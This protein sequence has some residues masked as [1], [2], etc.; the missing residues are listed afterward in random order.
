MSM[1]LPV[2]LAIALALQLSLQTAP[3][4]DKVT[5]SEPSSLA[6]EMESRLRLAHQLGRETNDRKL[7]ARIEAAAKKVKEKLA[8]NDNAGAEKLVREIEVAVGIDPGGWAVDGQKI[9]HP[10]P[11]LLKAAD[12]VKPAFEAALAADDAGA[13]RDAVAKWR[14]ALG[15]QAGLPDARR[16]GKRAPIKKNSEAEAVDIFLKALA[17]ESKAVREIS[18]GRPVGKNMLRF[19]AGIVS[20]ICDIRAAVERHQPKQLSMLDR[21]A[22]GACTIMER[23]QQPSGFFPF[24]DLRGE[25]I[26]FGEMTEKLLAQGKG[27]IKDGWLISVDPTGGTQFDTGVCGA[28]LLQAGQTF[29]NTAWIKAGL[30]AADWARTQKCCPNFNYNAF[31]VTL[32]GRAFRATSDAT[33]LDAAL[34]KFRV[35]VAPGQVANGRWIDAHNARTVYHHIILRGLNDLAEA[36][37]AN[38]VSELAEVEAVATPAVQALLDEWDA[39]GVTVDLL[40]ELLRYEDRHPHEPRLRG[41]IELSASVAREKSTR[42]L[43]NRFGAP[44]TELAALARVWK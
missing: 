23:A 7:V 39:S 35:G 30:R 24:P 29:T 1:T 21:V 34:K 43:S 12:A 25:N 33:Y 36:L 38:R 32:L 3:A 37:P 20:A 44:P 22:T 26:R 16:H 4:A 19:Y 18:S 40:A 11:A 6:T 41:A 42:G 27:E 17:S 31:S 5:Q 14:E 9:F 8:A 10:T 2:W 13:V 15:D 28:A